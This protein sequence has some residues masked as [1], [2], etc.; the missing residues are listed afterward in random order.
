MLLLERV[1]GGLHVLRRRAGLREPP[2]R[3]KHPLLL[4]RQVGRQLV[5]Q[6]PVDVGQLAQL[7]VARAVDLGHLVGHAA[8]AGQVLSQ[9]RV[10]AGDDVVEQ[11]P[12]RGVGEDAV[13]RDLARGGSRDLGGHRLDGGAV[14][15]AGLAERP[16][17]PAAE[18]DP[19]ALEDLDAARVVGRDVRDQGKG[20]DLQG[21]SSV[22]AVP[23]ETH[24][25]GGRKMK[26]RFILARS[27]AR[28][29]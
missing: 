28:A 29:T 16:A 10:V 24:A 5:A 27:A 7:G 22:G 12:E 2:Q 21:C 15:A 8:E 13:F 19:V 6:L 20:G 3:R 26:R 25:G 23:P 14:L 17:A 9:H 4:G 1:E 18:V 11:L